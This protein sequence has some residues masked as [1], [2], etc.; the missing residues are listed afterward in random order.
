MKSTKYH[1]HLRVFYQPNLLDKK[2]YI[3]NTKT[4]FLFDLNKKFSIKVN[5]STS[6]E[7][8]IITGAQ[9]DIK[10]FTMGFNLSI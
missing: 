5:Y 8:F 10:N 2:D 1:T 4:T 6:F 9:N 3:T 7:S